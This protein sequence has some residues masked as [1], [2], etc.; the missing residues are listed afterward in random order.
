M[1]SFFEF[2]NN[3]NIIPVPELLLYHCFKQIIDRDKSKNKFKSILELGYIW[4]MCN[5]SV[6]KNP[7]YLQF[8][9]DL[10]KKSEA[11]IND[12]F[13]TKWTPDELIQECIDF[14]NS[15]NYKES[16]DTRD[17]LLI[18]KTRLKQWFKNYDP[19]VDTDGLQLQRNSKS[20]QDLT[21]TIKEY[22][23][24]I[25]KEEEHDGSR[26]TGGGEVGAFEDI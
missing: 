13:T 7:Y 19:E 4:Y 14:Y 16:I 6:V 18:A 26:I 2:D 1:D 21:K 23:D 12:L 20:I 9:D 24:I 17:A 15:H 10:N 3:R 25:S 8:A 22:D 5:K 11:I